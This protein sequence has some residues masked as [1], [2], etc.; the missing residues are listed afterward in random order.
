PGSA[1]SIQKWKA[2]CLEKGPSGLE[3]GA[4]MHPRG[5]TAP[6]LPNHR[7]RITPE[8]LSLTQTISPPPMGDASLLL[9]AEEIRSGY[10]CLHSADGFYL[11]LTEEL[12]K[13]GSAEFL[14]FDKRVVNVAAMNA[15]TVKV[16]LL[17]S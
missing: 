17:P 16:N 4:R 9:R 8:P 7:H 15:P 13:S 14:T 3:G 12:A 10:S 1:Q 5:A 6:T 11:A 2:G